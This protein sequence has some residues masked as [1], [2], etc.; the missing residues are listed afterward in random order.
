MCQTFKSHLSNISKQRLNKGFFSFIDMYEPKEYL[1]LNIDTYIVSL[2]IPILTNYIMVQVKL[3]KVQR[4][5]IPIKSN[6]II[7]YI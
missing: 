4:K 3:D 6:Y 5:K 7:I 2:V 1:F